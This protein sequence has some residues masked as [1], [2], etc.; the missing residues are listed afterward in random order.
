MG[1][2]D[3]LLS[4]ILTSILFTAVSFVYFY[5]SRLLTLRLQWKYVRASIAFSAPLIPYAWKV[6]SEPIRQVVY[7]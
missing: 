7:F 1:W 2:Q 3:R 6:C 5:R 4:W